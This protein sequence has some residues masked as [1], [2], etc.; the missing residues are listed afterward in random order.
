MYSIVTNDVLVS[1]ATAQ[2]LIDWARLDSDDPKIAGTLLVATRLVISFLSLELLPRTYAL[3]YE[4]WPVIGTFGTS[5]LSPVTHASKFRVNIPYAN[6]LSTT[7]VTVNGDV[8]TTDDYKIVKGKPDLIQFNSVGYSTT[9]NTALQV[10]YSAGYG[11]TAADIPAPIIQAILMCS[12]YIHSHSGGCDTGKAVS[13]S[14]AAEL[15][16]PYAVMGGLV[17]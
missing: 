17:F 16:R 15:L 6:L 2:E 3:T 4:D 9:E 11:A 10:V 12:A 1:P 13:D 5:A 7:S 8:L 14:G